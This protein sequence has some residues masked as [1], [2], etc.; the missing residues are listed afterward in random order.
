MNKD[1]LF[2]IPPSRS[3]SLQVSH[4]KSKAAEIIGQ[5]YGVHSKAHMT[6]H[7]IYDQNPL[8]VEFALQKIK[9]RMSELPCIDI[10]INGF[11]YFQH[12]DT[13]TIYTAIKGTYQI[14]NWFHAL[15]K[16]FKKCTL[17]VPHITITRSISADHFYKLWPQFKHLTYQDTF[18][19][20][21]VLV[22]E[23]STVQ[24]ERNYR[25][26]DVIH[27]RNK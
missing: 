17:T 24:G 13:M 14:D 7:N 1:Y 3:I 5:Y 11:N 12:G 20:D 6:I 21:K 23:K 25:K 27:F 8:E 2:V 16:C 15:K 4:C 18:I 10:G 9:E 22:F 26:I 19:A